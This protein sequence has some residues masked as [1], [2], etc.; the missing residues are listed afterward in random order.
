MRILMRYDNHV[1]RA[2]RRENATEAQMMARNKNANLGCTNWNK[3]VE[4]R[5]AARLDRSVSVGKIK[6]T[7]FYWDVIDLSG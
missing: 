7:T 3:L 4:T 5:V 2:G 6:Q 1:W